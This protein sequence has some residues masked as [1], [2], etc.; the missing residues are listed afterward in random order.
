MKKKKWIFNFI[1]TGGR[2]SRFSAPQQDF[3]R[4]FSALLYGVP[5]HIRLI[6]KLLQTSRHVFRTQM[7]SGRTIL[8]SGNT[9]K[10]VQPIIFMKNVTVLCQ[11]VHDLHCK[12]NMSCVCHRNEIIYWVDGYI[13]LFKGLHSSCT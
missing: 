4:I 9:R 3:Q 1:K 8:S 12:N 11:K 13:H 7:T 5:Y 10:S 6:R 2:K